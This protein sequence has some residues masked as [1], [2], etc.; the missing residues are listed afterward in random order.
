ML[1]LF[2]IWGHLDPDVQVQ[3]ALM[4]FGLCSFA[5]AERARLIDTESP[6][7]ALVPEDVFKEDLVTVMER[8]LGA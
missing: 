8:V 4:A 1:H 7:R 3:R 2:P 6:P 5:L